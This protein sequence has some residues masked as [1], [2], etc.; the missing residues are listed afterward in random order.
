MVLSRFLAALLAGF[1]LASG[2][3]LADEVQEIDQQYRTGDRTGALE[4]VELYLVKNPKNAK[5]RFL[6]GLI[7]T[8]Q[9]RIDDAIEVMSALTE[10]YPELPE[11]YNNLAVLHASQG[12]Y[13]TAMHA[14]EAAI[15]AHPNYATAHENLGDLHAKMAS[16]AYEKAVTLD[17][18]NTAAQTKLTLIRGLLG[19]Q[20]AQPAAA[21]PA[22]AASK[23]VPE[24]GE[25]APAR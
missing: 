8:D 16:I 18:K 21:K 1:L 25:P 19:Q 11:P 10:D 13:Q 20:A 3:V 5:A 22:T 15:R 2:P 23:A 9:N 14:L 7:L 6:R 12:R 24:S 4:R 17:S